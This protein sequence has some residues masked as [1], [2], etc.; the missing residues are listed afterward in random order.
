MV[1]KLGYAKALNEALHQLLE[2]DPGVFILG[3]GVDNPW[4]VGATATGLVDRFGRDRV[5]DPPISENGMN[6]FAVGAALT[7]MKPILIHPR[8]DFLIYGL[9]QIMNQASNWSYVFRGQLSVPLVLWGIINRG[10][11]QGAQHSQAIQATFAHF[12]G[13]KVVMPATPYDA[14]GLL[15]SAVRDPNPVVFIDDRW[16]YKQESHVPEEM[17]EVPIG[18]AE[19]LREGTDVTLAATS[20]MVLL[21]LEAAEKLHKVGVSAEVLNLRS[22]KPL[23]EAA[24]LR[25]LQR[26]GRLVVADGG[27]R[28]FGAAAEVAAVAADKGFEHLEA[29]VARFTLPDAPAPSSS[30]EERAYYPTADQLVET[31]L[32]TFKGK[33]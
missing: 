33:P 28:S 22:L 25:S 31:A 21:A 30:A 17:Y 10:G 2:Q 12:P 26:T 24:I 27:W 20:H 16:L 5:I 23:D 7:G 13:L 1:R 11:E 15:I 8:L 3:Q 6:G 4:Y 32:R 14:K 29:P 18:K 9:D 19:V